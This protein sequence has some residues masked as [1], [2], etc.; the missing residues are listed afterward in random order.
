VR[1]VIRE[2]LDRRV[3]LDPPEM[4]HSVAGVVT[5]PPK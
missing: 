3:Q 4:G 1:Q 2:H 5:G